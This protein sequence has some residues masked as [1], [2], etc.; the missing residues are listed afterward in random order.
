M[1][2]C[3]WPIDYVFLLAYCSRYYA[4]FAAGKRAG[5]YSELSQK[6]HVS[7]CVCENKITRRHVI[8]RDAK[9]ASWANMCACMCM[10][11]CHALSSSCSNTA[12]PCTSDIRENACVCVRACVCV[13]VCVCACMDSCKATFNPRLPTWV[14]SVACLKLDYTCVS[15]CVCVCVHGLMQGNI[16][17][18]IACFQCRLSRRLLHVRVCMY[19]WTRAW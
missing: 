9:K 14:S 6:M 1:C 3:R 13:C 7:L 10:C 17:S 5:R 8:V 12:E 11:A 15:V 16:Q 19:V 4:G 18:I 2:P